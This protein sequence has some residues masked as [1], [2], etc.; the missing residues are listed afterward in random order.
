MLRRARAR[1]LAELTRR[2]P[3]KIRAL[4]AELTKVV[5]LLLLN[6]G[7]KAHLLVQQ[8]KALR[9][10]LQG[11]P[12]VVHRS[13]R[14]FLRHRIAQRGQR[15]LR[16]WDPSSRKPLRFGLL[17]PRLFVLKRLNRSRLREHVG[18][19]A[20]ARVALV[21]RRHLAQLELRLVARRAAHGLRRARK[22]MVVM[23]VVAGLVVGQRHQ[24]VAELQVPSVR[25]ARAFLLVVVPLQAK[26]GPVARSSPSRTSSSVKNAWLA[27]RASSSSASRTSRARASRWLIS[28]PM[29]ESASR[30][31]LH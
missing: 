21:V 28:Q 11:R 23:H 9:R 19:W 24:L 29:G 3:I 26:S 8:P 25:R 20:Q 13:V 2:V 14:W 7:R 17:A 15:A 16:R 10:V 12:L 31:H 27:R 30:L 22:M 6:L 4:L 5:V 1:L 18:P